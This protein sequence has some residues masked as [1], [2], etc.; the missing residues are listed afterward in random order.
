M[1]NKKIIYVAILVVVSISLIIVSG[2][3]IKQ[4]SKIISDY[5]SLVVESAR[6]VNESS[7]LTSQMISTILA[8]NDEVYNNCLYDGVEKCKCDDCIG[9]YEEI[10]FNEVKNEVH[11]KCLDEF[12][13]LQ[14]EDVEMKS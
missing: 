2:Y 1:I 12:K 8:G 5:S 10:C 13:L 11:D 3:N 4:S 7:Y 14:Q 6:L 9:G